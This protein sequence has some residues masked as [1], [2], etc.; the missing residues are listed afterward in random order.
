MVTGYLPTKPP[1]HGLTVAGWVGEC[2]RE[3]FWDSESYRD[4]SNQEITVFA[5]AYLEE[6][7][8]A[9]PA[10]DILTR[11]TEETETKPQVGD[12][13]AAGG[14]PLPEMYLII[15][16]SYE[17][18]ITYIRWMRRDKESTAK[19]KMSDKRW[20]SMIA[21]AYPQMKLL[22]RDVPEPASTFTSGLSDRYYRPA[23]P[24]VG[25]HWVSKLGPR[26][27]IQA[28]SETYVEVRLFTKDEPVVPLFGRLDAIHRAN[29][30]RV[31]EENQLLL[32]CES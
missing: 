9:C 18:E 17:G 20:K 31:I 13:W 30:P 14:G 26:L 8:D 1:P 2:W 24:I 19:D 6:F 12:L 29:F 16:I 11:M 4:P 27:Y 3:V 23:V 25:Q 28:V 32:R 22:A 7:I 21:N 15:A 10:P 5:W